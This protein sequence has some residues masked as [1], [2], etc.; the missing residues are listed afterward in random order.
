MTALWIL[1]GILAF[2]VIL[3][4]IPIHVI[5]EADSSLN[6]KVYARVLFIKYALFPMQKRKKKPKKAKKSGKKAVPKPKKQAKATPKPKPKR[7]IIGLVKLIL[8]LVSAVLKKFPRHFRVRV[9][10]YE[11]SVGTKDA[12]KTAM[13][14]GAVTGLSANL[15]ELLKKGTR[16]RIGRKAPVGVYANFIGEK[17]EA[18]ICLDISLTITDALH[19]VMAA[20]LAFVKAKMTAKSKPQKNANPQATQNEQSKK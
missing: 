20:G 3:F 8:K 4:S 12:A 14:Y 2:F 6:A 5:V 18:Y 11:I 10:R 17:T 15:F 16:F 1:L 7:D 13:V 9:L 19:M